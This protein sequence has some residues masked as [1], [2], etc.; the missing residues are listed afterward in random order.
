MA[1]VAGVRGG[2]VMGAAKEDSAAMP[3]L[4]TSAKVQPRLVLN[5]NFG[6]SFS[7]SDLCKGT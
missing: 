3:A 2:G 4:K 6:I 5:D 7:W 1:A